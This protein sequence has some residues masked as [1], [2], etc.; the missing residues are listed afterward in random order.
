MRGAGAPPGGDSA[1]ATR[2]SAGSL[3][4]RAAGEPAFLDLFGWR[5]RGLFASSLIMMP[6]EEEKKK[7]F[8]NQ[9]G[10]RGEESVCVCV[11]ERE[12]ES[13]REGIGALVKA[14]KLRSLPWRDSGGYNALGDQG[15]ICRSWIKDDISTQ[16]R[17]SLRPASQ[18]ATSTY[19]LKYRPIQYLIHTPPR[20]GRG[21][22]ASHKLAPGF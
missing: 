22:S 20:N 16:F 14:I 17:V 11:C 3:R 7:V 18:E 19:F 9:T 5:R 15:F 6:R 1:R 8:K 10:W 4:W 13:E 2:V 12:R 21:T